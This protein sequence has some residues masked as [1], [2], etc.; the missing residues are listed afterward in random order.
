MSRLDRLVTEFETVA[1]RPWIPTLAG[2]QRVWMV[3]YDEADERRLR[4]RLGEFAHAAQKAG[5]AMRWCD[6]TSAFGEWMAAHELR[7]EYFEYP[8]DLLVDKGPLVAFREYAAERLRQ[9]LAQASD[10]EIVGVTGVGALLGLA[11]VSE[12]VE[13]THGD[14][15]GRLAV[16]FPGTRS[17]NVYRLLDAREGWNYL[18]LPISA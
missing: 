11:R 4:V 9:A 2:P 5:H 10:E 18:A 1:V 17:G 16:F 6:L 12:V 14:I 7:S 13:A 8:E 15:K 3:V